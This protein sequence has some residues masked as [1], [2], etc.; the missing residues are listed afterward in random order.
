MSL[1][2][3]PAVPAPRVRYRIVTELPAAARADTPLADDQV[4]L[5]F[6]LAGDT[7]TIVATGQCAAACERVL[8]SLGAEELG[9]E[10]CG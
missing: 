9:I 3:P 2:P 10:L 5:H 1:A 8:L 4:R 7:L 6:S